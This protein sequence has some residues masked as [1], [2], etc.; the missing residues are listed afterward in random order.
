VDDVERIGAFVD[1]A[2][3]PALSG[4]WYASEDPFHAAPWIEVAACDAADVDAAVAAARR[5]LRTSG[6]RERSA[7]DRADVLEAVAA[8]VQERAEELALDEVRDAGGTLRW[9][10]GAC[11]P[12]TADVF[13]KMAQL[14]REAPEVEARALEV[15]VE[16]ENLVEWLPIGVVGAI[17]P[18]NFPMA[19]AAW[20]IAAAIAAGNSIVLKPSPLTPVTALRLAA[21]CTE[22]GVPPG[23]VNVVPGPDG[24]LGEA[25]VRHPG[26]DMVAFT[27]S[28]VVGRAVMRACADAPKP[29]LLELGGKS[30]V[31]VRD[32]AP[33]DLTVPGLLFGTF[34]HAGQVCDSGTRILVS[35]AREAELLER[36]A[37]AAAALR[38]GDPMDPDTDVGP[39]A[40]AAQ[41]RR[42]AGWV[43]DA[44]AQGARVC[45]G[46]SVGPSGHSY[47]PTVLGGVTPDM[48]VAREEVFGPV[49]VVIPYDDEDHAVAIANDSPYGLAAGVWSADV[50]AALRLARRLEAG[51][52]WINDYHLLDASLPFGGTKRSGFGR[53][54]GVAGLRAYQQTRHLHVGRME[55][56]PY[57]ALLLGD[58]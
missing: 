25:L 10:F 5:A 2:S 45:C 52:V 16:S 11:I 46:G 33:L 12:G 42:V 24:A 32:D 30:P 21:L 29:V 19:A 41:Q 7:S 26:V 20:K 57:L 37:A 28:D 35:R 1:G 51:T 13:V 18:F 3:R 8:L 40:S 34:F 6:W 49:V 55:P 44:V 9:A 4:A 58:R 27:G 22:A 48:R 56:K 47:L 54:L 17:V 43:D 50:D 31:I 15:P 38:V 14:V 39:L 53:E 36:L 23:V